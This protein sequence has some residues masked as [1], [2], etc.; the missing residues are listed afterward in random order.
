M[1]TALSMTHEGRKL[2]SPLLIS[3]TLPSDIHPVILVRKATFN[4][5]TN[6]LLSGW[7]LELRTL[8]SK[9]MCR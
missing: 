2:P 4:D 9:V 5:R 6:L 3:L 1:P 7:D 8:F